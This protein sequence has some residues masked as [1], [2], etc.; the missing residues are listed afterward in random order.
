MSRFDIDIVPYV[1][2]YKGGEKVNE[3]H[4]YAGTEWMTGMLNDALAV[5]SSY[6]KPFTSTGD[7]KFDELILTSKLPILVC[8]GS[9]EVE[10]QAQVKWKRYH[11]LTRFRSIAVN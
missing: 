3:R 9:P 2:V 4:G 11:P 5:P 7:A 10:I 6:P 8:F 1:A